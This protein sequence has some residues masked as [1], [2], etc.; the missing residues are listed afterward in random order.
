MQELELTW[1]QVFR[2]WWAVFWR[3]LVLNQLTAGI[4]GAAI[5]IPLLI[6]GH[7]EWVRADGWIFVTLVAYVP[8]AVIAIRLAFKTKYKGFRVAIIATEAE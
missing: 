6:I 5:G 1:G 2:I 8:S 4:L 3:W 7:R